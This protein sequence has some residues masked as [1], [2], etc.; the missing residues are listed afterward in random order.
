MNKLRIFIDTEF[1]DFVD[2]SLI[3]LALVADTDPPQEFYVEISDF[4]R[5]S[6]NDFVV[7]NVLPQLNIILGRSM[8]YEEAKD[9]VGE[10]LNLFR[11]TGACICYVFIGD[12]I[13]LQK[14]LHESGK[15][16]KAADMS[17]WLSFDNIWTNLDRDLRTNFWRDHPEISE[18][19]AL[20]DA[21]A[22]L[23]AMSEVSHDYEVI[24]TRGP[25]TR[26]M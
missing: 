15:D 26:A 5:N 18:H 16:D 17:E 11:H 21:R 20:Y 3:A 2:P 7:A 8:S 13:L 9:R 12:L 14:M 24:S 25:R 23:A 19:H 6:C 4:D 22:N 1:T 10:W